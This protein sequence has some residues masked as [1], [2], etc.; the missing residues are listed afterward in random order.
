MNKH[1]WNQVFSSNFWSLLLGEDCV[2]CSSL[3]CT[4]FYVLC[5]I[6]FIHFFRYISHLEYC[7]YVLQ[8][9][10]KAQPILDIGMRIWKIDSHIERWYFTTVCRDIDSHTLNVSIA[11]GYYSFSLYVDSFIEKKFF[12][13]VFNEKSNFDSEKKTICLLI[14]KMQN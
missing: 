5:E 10:S 12:L 11:L 8:L 14:W 6:E 3:L 9:Y 1:Q 4:I 13:Y 7:A 2:F